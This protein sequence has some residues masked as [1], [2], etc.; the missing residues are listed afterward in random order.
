MQHLTRRHWLAALSPLLAAPILAQDA[1]PKERRNA[2][3]ASPDLYRAIAAFWEPH[4]RE[5]VDSLKPRREV[6]SGPSDC[7]WLQIF[8]H[9][10]QNRPGRSL[11]H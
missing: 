8:V 5:I 2:S 6:Q 4:E 11:W 10:L 3:N 9:S 1:Q 7:R